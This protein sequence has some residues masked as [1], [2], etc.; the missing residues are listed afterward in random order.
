ML[1]YNKRIFICSTLANISK[2]LIFN[3]AA[4]INILI[5]AYEIAHIIK[6]YIEEL[7]TRCMI[8]KARPESIYQSNRVS[9]VYFDD[10]TFETLQTLL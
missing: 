7:Q 4:L 2:H 3:T 1:L 5:V 8:P 6:D 9:S 10:H